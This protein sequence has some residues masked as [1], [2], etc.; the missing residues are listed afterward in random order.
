M[1]PKLVAYFGDRWSLA[2]AASTE[3]LSFNSS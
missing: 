1:L 3:G 2:L